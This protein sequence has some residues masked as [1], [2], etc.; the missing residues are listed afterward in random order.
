MKENYEQ[1]LRQHQYIETKSLILRPFTPE[2]REGVLAY[3]SDPETLQHLVWEGISTLEEAEASIT[4]SYLSKPGVYALEHKAQGQC[5]GCIDLRFEAAHEKASFGYVLNRSYWG[6]GY[7]AE[8]LRALIDLCFR[9]LEVN[10]IESTHYL[11]NEGSGRVM[12]KCGMGKEGLAL[13]EV[14]IKGIFRDVV[15]YG[16]TRD[17]WLT[18]IKF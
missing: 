6:R 9:A 17:Q 10:R 18:D 13:Q 12:E 3:G 5:I 1:I 8:A 16:I 11:G 15:H 14:K 4:N 2:D 7:M